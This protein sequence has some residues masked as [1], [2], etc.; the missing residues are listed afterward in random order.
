MPDT[1]QL[2]KQKLAN[3]RFHSIEAVIQ[4]GLQTDVEPTSP[5]KRKESFAK[6]MRRSPA[7]GSGIEIDERQPDPERQVD[8]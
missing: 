5:P 8:L 1:E 6:F 4:R 2:L 7:F 3:G